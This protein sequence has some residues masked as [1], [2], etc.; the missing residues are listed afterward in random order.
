MLSGALV[1]GAMDFEECNTTF[2][3]GG[4]SPIL[5]ADFLAYPAQPCSSSRRARSRF[6]EFLEIIDLVNWAVLGLKELFDG[7]FSSSLLARQPPSGGH[8]V[9]SAPMPSSLMSRLFFRLRA[10]PPPPSRLRGE[11]AVT[12]LRGSGGERPPALVEADSLGC[13]LP[14]RGDIYPAS[15]PLI[16]LPPA[17]SCP[18]PI[19]DLSPTAASYLQNVNAMLASQEEMEANLQKAPAQPF[20][21]PNLAEPDDALQLAKRMIKAGMVRRV[22]RRQ[23]SVGLFTVVKKAE[24][25]P[26]GRLILTLRLVFDQR[27]DNARWKR[28]PWIGLAGPSAIA[29]LDLSDVSDSVQIDIAAGDLPNYYY[30]LKLPPEFAEFFCLPDIDVERLCAELRQEDWQDHDGF[31]QQEGKFLGLQVPPMGWSWAVVLAQLTLQ[32]L[33]QGSAEP[34]KQ[35]W[36]PEQRIVEG[37]VTPTVSQEMPVHFAYIDDFGVIGLKVRLGPTS[38]ATEMK[39]LAVASIQSKGLEVHKETEG[40][41]AQVLGLMVGG[42]PP[43]VLPLEEKKWLLV[44]ACRHLS[45]QT[46]VLPKVIESVVAMVTW[47]FLIQRSTLSIFEKVYPWIRLHRDLRGYQ[48]ISEAVRKELSLVACVLPLLGQRLDSQWSLEVFEVDASDAG[49]AIIATKAT[50]AEVREEGRWAARGGW[51]R[52]TEGCQWSQGV[53]GSAEPE[54][55]EEMIMPPYIPPKP[56]RV[57]RFLH[58]FS[59]HRRH[60]DIEYYLRLMGAARG[61]L[62]L[63]LNVDLAF[64][65]DYDLAAPSNVERLIDEILAGLYDGMHTA[66]PCSTWSPVRWRP[67]GPP[68]LRSRDSPWGMLGLSEAHRKLVAL[69][70]RLMR[71]SCALIEAMAKKG[72]TLTKEHPADR[73]C[74]PFASIFATA[75]WRALTVRLGLQHVTFPQCMFGAPTKKPTTLAYCN[76]DLAAFNRLCTHGRHGEVLCGLDEE[77]KFKTRAAQAYPPEVCEELARAHLQAWEKREPFLEESQAAE[78]VRMSQVEQQPDLGTRVPVPEVGTNWDPISRWKLLVAWKWRQSEHNNV[79]EMRAAVA[80]FDRATRSAAFWE[81]RILVISDSQVTIGALGKG[82]S[83]IPVINR[84]CRRVAAL[85]LAFGIKT[86]LRYVRTHRNVADGPSRGQPLGYAAGPPPVLPERS[87]G[88]WNMLPDVFYLKTAG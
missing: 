2:A 67:G 60:G 52:L 14:L 88:A 24:M 10:F 72:G 81:K 18:V 59:G 68:P 80:A 85:V 5:R 3:A 20:V 38:P 70:S 28:P 44:E 78:L 21:D 31:L 71:A 12:R 46:K 63:V 66:P 86:Y 7:V 36:S 82:R 9:P 76:V 15:I 8:Q 53:L 26:D 41:V 16:A 62:V 58:L 42:A 22:H 19:V 37:A 32:D 33:L 61:W 11:A 23:G 57:Y 48:T 29:A 25:G 77:G 87:G 73:G 34:H 13:A 83:P 30:T 17:G 40:E 54:E 74:H 65:K 50:L 47:L 84:L 56:I 39:K 49:A 27:R 79:L 6:K 75:L 51:A 64:G 4:T 43:M 69:H 55:E 35:M 45:Q 1:L